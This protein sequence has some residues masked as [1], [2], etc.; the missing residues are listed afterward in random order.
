MR[1]EKAKIKLPPSLAEG[2]YSL[3]PLRAEHLHV[4]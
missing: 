3:D 4:N 2:L 1:K